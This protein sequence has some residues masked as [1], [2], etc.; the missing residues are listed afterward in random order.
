MELLFQKKA[1]MGNSR[2]VFQCQEARIFSS[3]SFRNLLY[4][5]IFG[6]AVLV[7]LH[8][9]LSPE[10]PSRGEG[11]SASRYR[12]VPFHRRDLFPAFMETNG[13]VSVCFALAVSQV[14]LIQN[15]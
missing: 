6:S 12:Y 7:A 8:R 4:V 11:P 9:L 13:R 3:F 14:T 10:S 15:Y 1:F 2:K 5:S